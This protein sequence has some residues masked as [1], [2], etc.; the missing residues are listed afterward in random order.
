M[1]WRVVV[2]ADSATTATLAGE[3][4]REASAGDRSLLV[5]ASPN[6]S[7]ADTHWFRHDVDQF[8]FTRAIEAGAMRP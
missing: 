3:P 8:F 1:T 5:A 2:N 7:L 4:F 6:D